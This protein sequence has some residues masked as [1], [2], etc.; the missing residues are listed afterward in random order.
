MWQRYTD[1]SIL[2]K[3]AVIFK[4]HLNLKLCSEPLLL[5]F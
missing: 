1:A 3:E 5:R 4:T 2:L